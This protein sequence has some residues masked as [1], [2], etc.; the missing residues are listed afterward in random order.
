MILKRR[1]KIAPSSAIGIPIRMFARLCV[2]TKGHMTTYSERKRFFGPV[3]RQR[4]YHDPKLAN[5]AN[6]LLFEFGGIFLN[7][8]EM[9]GVI[10]SG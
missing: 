1:I 7:I 10:V 2:T 5:E 3:K 6:Y 8:A 9:T 4:R